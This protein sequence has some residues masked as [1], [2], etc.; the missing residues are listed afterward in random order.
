MRYS[1][2]AALAAP[3]VG[4]CS[5]PVGGSLPMAY[6]VGA[7]FSGGEIAEIESAI[8]TW[9]LWGVR[10]TGHTLFYSGNAAY[11]MSLECGRVSS[12]GNGVLGEFADSGDGPDVILYPDRIDGT[13]T[14]LESVTLH[15]LGHS[16]GLLD[17]YQDTESTMYGHANPSVEI[18]SDIE[19]KFCEQWTC[20]KDEVKP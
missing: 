7:G 1:I 2:L 15:E 19:K 6:H 8:S 13:V 4:A 14:N 12:S 16:L 5:D 11:S 10:E 18:S 17:D 9:N 3:L 20:K